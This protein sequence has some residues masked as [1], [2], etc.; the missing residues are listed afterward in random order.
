MP[1]RPILLLVCLLCSLSASALT[2]GD[3]RQ[4]TTDGGYHPRWSPDG[5]SI[6]FVAG[7]WPDIGLFIMP[8]D[9][10]EPQAVPL[11]LSG[12]L[13]LSW[14]PDGRRLAFDAYRSDNGRLGIHQVNLDDGSVSL[15]VDTPSVASGPAWRPDGQRIAF[16]ASHTGN[17]DIYTADAAG[18]DLQRLTITPG[19]D[20]Y[21]GWS[22]GGGFLAYA[23]NTAGN[24]DVWIH[25]LTTGEVTRFTDHPAL[26]GRPVWSPDGLWISFTSMRSGARQVYAQAVA[27]GG[28]ILLSAGHGDA[29]MSEWAPDGSAICYVAD[30]QLWVLEIGGIT[31]V[32]PVSLS[33]LK[34]GFR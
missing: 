6:A 24:D 3:R 25:D 15:L 34:A 18:G 13:S 16:T 9:G 14:H 32:A 10:G 30:G 2:L 29:S 5:Q 11:G 20:W 17:G 23:T 8:A 21:A 1:Q 33:E 27:G 31:P 12:D 22:P 19:V 26:D 28:P 7:D 4:L